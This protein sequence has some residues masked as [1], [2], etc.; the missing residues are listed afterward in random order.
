MKRL[1][2]KIYIYKFARGNDFINSYGDIPNGF[3][4]LVERVAREVARNIKN[5]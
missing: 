2:P 5:E 4:E 3:N 1:R